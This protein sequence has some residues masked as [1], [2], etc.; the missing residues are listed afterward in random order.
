MYAQ[1]TDLHN[2]LEALLSQHQQLAQRFE[3]RI[4]YLETQ[5]DSHRQRFVADLS[6]VEVWLSHVYSLMCQE[7]A[8]EGVTGYGGGLQPEIEEEEEENE[9]RS[10]EKEGGEEGGEGGYGEGRG[11]EERGGEEKEEVEKKEEKSWEEV[12][13][14]E[15]TYVKGDQEIGEEEEEEAVSLQWVKTLQVLPMEHKMIIEEPD[16]DQLDYNPTAPDIDAI[17]ENLEVPIVFN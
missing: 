10:W 5:L 12:K 17:L 9:D 2:R 13:E 15:E 16:F 11:G 7:P 8:R 3:E 6:D 1:V 14:E 4:N